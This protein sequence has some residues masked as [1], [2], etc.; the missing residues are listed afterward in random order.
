[1]PAGQGGL[2][3]LR[4]PLPYMLR[5]VWNDHARYEKYWEQIPGVYTAATWRSATRTATSRCSVAPTRC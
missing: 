2:L 5:T 4:K 3:V 1:M